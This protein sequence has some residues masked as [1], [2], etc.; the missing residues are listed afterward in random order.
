LADGFADD[1]PPVDLDLDDRNEE[2]LLLAGAVTVSAAA[3]I[4]PTA[5]PVAAPLSISPATSNTLSSTRD[6]VVLA[7]L[8][9]FLPDAEVVFVLPDLDEPDLLAITFSSQIF[10]NML[11][12]ISKLAHGPN[13]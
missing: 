4:A 5:A 2:R 8:D 11:P 3:P 1:R 7:E 13:I 9:L 10:V 12:V 6:A